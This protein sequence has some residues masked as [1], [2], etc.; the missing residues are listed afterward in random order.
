MKEYKTTGAEWLY[1]SMATFNGSGYADKL[2]AEAFLDSYHDY[3]LYK[4]HTHALEL[5]ERYP[6]EA[7]EFAGHL[8]NAKDPGRTV[9]DKNMRRFLEFRLARKHF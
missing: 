4:D 6:D 9:S 2:S 7:L 3:K 8:C 1:L 5:L